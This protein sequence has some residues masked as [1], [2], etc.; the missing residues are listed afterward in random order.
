ML[1][2]IYIIDVI[3]VIDVIGTGT[4]I[5]LCLVEEVKELG[6]EIPIYFS[7]LL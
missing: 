6:Y 2:T 5:G 4:V 3:D 7:L 1:S